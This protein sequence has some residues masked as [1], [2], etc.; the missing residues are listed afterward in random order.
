MAMASLWQLMDSTVSMLMNALARTRVNKI[1]L[2][3]KGALHAHVTLGSLLEMME[4]LVKV[5]L[6]FFVP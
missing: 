3:L 5:R 2:T 4:Q 6:L 1:V